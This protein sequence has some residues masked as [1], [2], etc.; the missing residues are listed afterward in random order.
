M[1]E[2]R[3]NT[4][5][6]AKEKMRALKL[7]KQS[8]TEFVCHRYHCSERSLWRWKAKYDGTVESLENKSHRPHTPHP[9]SQTDE[10]IKHIR[11]LIRRN[12]KIGLNELYGKLRLHY[13]YSRNPATLY[14]YLRRTGFYENKS[15]Q[16]PYK[17]KPYDTPLHLGEKWQLDVKFVPFEC[18]TT[19]VRGDRHFYQYTIIDEASRE[20]FIYP[21]E[22]LCATST[23]DFVRRAIV[24]FGYKPK[25]IQTDNGSEFTYTRQTRADKEHSF[26]KF[27]RLRGI[28]HKLIKPRTPRHNGKVERS[29]RSDN[30]RFYKWLKFYDFNDLLK[31][32]KAYL[33]RSNEIP[34]STLKSCD[35]T[36]KWLTPLEKRA[37]LLLTDFG[38]VEETRGIPL[39]RVIRA[40]KSK[41]I[42]VQVS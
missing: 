38:V 12:P 35:G 16:T 13:A 40:K 1:K 6:S 5:Y 20:R 15:K 34:I 33:Q 18:R 28:K 42:T 29:H 7:W 30:E 39:A 41:S 36:K 19:A 4:P 23:V 17:P 10:E 3:Y 37:D 22:D 14:R 2:K 25:E 21:Y 32:M 26:D 9:N 11:D 8:T 31:Q 27:C 24:Y